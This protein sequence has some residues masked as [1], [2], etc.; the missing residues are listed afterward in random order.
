[1]FFVL[2]SCNKEK[3]ADKKLDGNWKVDLVRIED[4]EGFAFYDS[5]PSGTLHFETDQHLFSG[6]INY[7]YLNFENQY[8]YDTCVYDTA[9]YTYLDAKADHISF[10]NN[11]QVLNVRFVVLTKTAMVFEYY[12]LSKY[13]MIRYMLYKEN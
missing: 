5:I 2:L 7:K 12:D 1:M 3:L 13:R 10:L 9:T 6:Q 4:G 8:I 11:G